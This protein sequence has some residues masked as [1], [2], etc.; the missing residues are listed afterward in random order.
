M[1]SLRLGDAEN[2]GLPATP[3]CGA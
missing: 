3:L 2:T 1:F